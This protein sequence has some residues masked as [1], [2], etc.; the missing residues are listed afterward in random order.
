MPAVCL[1]KPPKRWLIYGNL[2]HH[3]LSTITKENHR[4]FLEARKL[5]QQVCVVNE[6]S[7]TVEAHVFEYL[8]P[9]RVLPLLQ[10]TDASFLPFA[11]VLLQGFKP[12]EI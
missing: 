2:T 9:T 7:L 5:K 11:G 10:E 1:G 12:L 8:L 6:P 4:H 3:W